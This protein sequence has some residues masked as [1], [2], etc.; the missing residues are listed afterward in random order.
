MDTVGGGEGVGGTSGESS[1]D[2]YT[3]ICKTDS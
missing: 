1:M 3:A 2:T